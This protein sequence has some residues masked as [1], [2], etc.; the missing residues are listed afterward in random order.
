MAKVVGPLHSLAAHG[1][2]AKQLTF[3]RV[4]SN[5]VV[6]EYAKPTDRKSSAQTA[7]RAGMRDARAAWRALSAEQKESWRQKAVGIPGTSG[8]NLFIKQ[9]LKSY[10]SDI[11]PVFDAKK[12]D[13]VCFC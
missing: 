3:R 5:N 10:Y 9:Y 2:F 11:K 7:H 1:D 13:E 4:L 12:F 6:S 8:Y